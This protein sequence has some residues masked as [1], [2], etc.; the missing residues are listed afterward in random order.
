[1]QLD[2]HRAVLDA[3]REALARG[4]TSQETF[5]AV[6]SLVCA[7]APDLAPHEA[8]RLAAQMLCW[9]PGPPTVSAKEGKNGTQDVCS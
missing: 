8:R 9:D 4:R 6:A 5:E 2:L 3:Y 7:N 1:M